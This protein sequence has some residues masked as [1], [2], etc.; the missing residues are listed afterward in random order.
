[1]LTIELVTIKLDTAT[2][3]RTDEIDGIFDKA[4]KV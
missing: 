2:K 1:M 3:K 4:K